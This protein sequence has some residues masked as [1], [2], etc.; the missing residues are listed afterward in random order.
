MAAAQRRKRLNGVSVGGC[1][2]L[3]QYRMKKSKL[4]LPQNGLNSKSNISLQWDESKKKVIAKQE[5]IGISRR[6]LK[7][8]TDSVS[9]SKNVLGHLADAFS[10]PQE[11]F[12]LENLT[13]VLSHEVAISLL[14]LLHIILLQIVLFEAQV[15]LHPFVWNL[16]QVWQTQLSEEERN[17]LKQFLPSAQNA[18]QV[19]EALLAGEN[20][21]F[22][23]PFLKW[24]V[25]T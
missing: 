7:P 14:L 5:Q 22:G 18:E 19:V 9:G 6:I 13:E 15:L 25:F 1:S 3:E 17:Y 2:P 23:S 21:H 16:L 12:E 24:Q 4:G 10:V 11:T 8:F 20:F